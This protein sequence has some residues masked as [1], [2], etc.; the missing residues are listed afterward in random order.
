MQSVASDIMQGARRR[1]LQLLQAAT[2]GALPEADDLNDDAYRLCR[3]RL[4]STRN[5]GT[6]IAAVNA[7]TGN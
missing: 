3:V 4:M 6:P 2:L 1:E 7:P 5:S